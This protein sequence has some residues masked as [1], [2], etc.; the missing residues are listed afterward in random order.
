MAGKSVTTQFRAYNIKAGKG[1][2]S[3]P[4]IL[5]DT[6]GLEENA[7]AGLDL[8]DLVNICKGHMQDRY[9][10]S[11]S[12]PLHSDAPGYK[13]HVTLSDTIHCVVY[14]IDTCKV[15]LLSQKMLEKL[16][17]IR[18][19]TNQLGIPQILLM[20]KVDEAC[21]LVAED[22]KNVYQSVYIQ[23]KARD[24]SESL[25]IPLFCILPVKN[26]SEE[27]DLDLNTD[28]L[29]FSAVEQMLNYA[30]N[31]FENQVVDDIDTND[32]F[33]LYRSNDHL[34]PVLSEQTEPHL[35]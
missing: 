23:R 16:A 27:V 9:Q 21:P 12:A 28:I 10:F 20:T 31:F 3:V 8:E 6:M 15:S 33:E 2:G 11:P 19:K 5:C 25:G 30:D 7:D 1:C 35:V 13:K 18:K 17:T 34:C 22:L 32:Q 24:L 14:V 4:L 29:L 26:Y